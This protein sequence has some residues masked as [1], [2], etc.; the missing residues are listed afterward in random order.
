M[1]KYIKC[2]EE[3][4]NI[5]RVDKITDMNSIL[6]QARN[7]ALTKRY[8]RKVASD[9]EKKEQPR[10]NEEIRR[11]IKERKEGNRRKRN[12][13][14]KDKRKELETKY[15]QKKE[16]VQKLV[17]ESITAY[18]KMITEE[19][20]R[21]KNKLW[22]NINKLRNKC[23]MNSKAIQLYNEEGLLLGTE[24]FKKE[25]LKHKSLENG[26]QWT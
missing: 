11:K 5:N 14:N 25:L 26:I 6:V 21:D 9:D 18:E 15:I 22:V 23:G 20:K 19:V 12:E 13:R 7:E 2:V 1:E 17:K 8:K 10:V 24:E 4:I 3:R 16:E